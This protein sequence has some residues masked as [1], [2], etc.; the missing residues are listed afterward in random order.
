MID[1]G[2]FIIIIRLF[3]TRF[4]CL[5]TVLFVCVLCMLLG[6]KVEI[7]HLQWMTQNIFHYSPSSYCIVI[8]F[9]NDIVLLLL[10]S[11]HI[12]YSYPV[13]RA[14]VFVPV[15]CVSF[16]V[17]KHLF[18]AYFRAPVPQLFI[19]FNKRTFSKSSC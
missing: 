13:V 3:I 6:F 9:S 14:I 19:K 11:H 5:L 2:K 10:H 17:S 12:D 8:N 4:S 18:I 1:W 16:L 15:T 7:L